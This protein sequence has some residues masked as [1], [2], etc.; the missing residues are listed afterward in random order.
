M[1]LASL[2]MYSLYNYCDVWQPKLAETSDKLV[3]HKMLV[4]TN[5]VMLATYV[6]FVTTGEKMGSWSPYYIYRMNNHESLCDVGI[7]AQHSFIP[8]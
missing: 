8:R 6:F 3:I 5:F 2:I 7:S 4:F 1:C